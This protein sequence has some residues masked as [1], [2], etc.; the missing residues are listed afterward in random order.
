M[1][2]QQL[3]KVRVASV[4]CFHDAALPPG[5]CPDWVEADHHLP[6]PRHPGPGSLGVLGL[7]LWESLSWI[8]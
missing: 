5:G 6:A 3:P 7:L 8:L 2:R 1:L 4:R